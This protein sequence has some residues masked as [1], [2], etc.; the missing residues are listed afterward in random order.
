[1]ATRATLKNGQYWT[2]W[3]REEKIFLLD[4]GNPLTLSYDEYKGKSWHCA[5]TRSNAS[6]RDI[7]KL[8]R[9]VNDDPCDLEKWWILNFLGKSWDELYIWGKK[10][11]NVALFQ[12]QGHIVAVRKYVWSTLLSRKIDKISRKWR[13]VRPREMVNIEPFEHEKRRLFKCTQGNH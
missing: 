6:S 10:T 11:I 5:N 13:S 3:A 1:M 2:F 8:P 4:A 12:T 7:G 9:T